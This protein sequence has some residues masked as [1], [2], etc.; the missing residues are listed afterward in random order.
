MPIVIQRQNSASSETSDVG[1]PVSPTMLGNFS[2]P[3][4]S[5]KILMK[6]LDFNH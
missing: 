1:S 2:Y 4:K 5:Q 3:P 6:E